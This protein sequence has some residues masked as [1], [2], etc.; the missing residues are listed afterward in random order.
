M[1]NNAAKRYRPKWL[2]GAWV[3]VVGVATAGWLIGLAWAA[4]WLV[5][6]AIS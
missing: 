2:I 5:Q 6:R 4:V 1:K 3:L